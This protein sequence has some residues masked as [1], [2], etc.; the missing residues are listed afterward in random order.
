MVTE[1]AERKQ[2][3]A[4]AVARLREGLDNVLDA[5]EE[6]EA[7]RERQR[8]ANAELDAEFWRDWQSEK[9]W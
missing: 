7:R 3:L 1:K 2:R 5:V 4:A 8:D 6:R 9:D